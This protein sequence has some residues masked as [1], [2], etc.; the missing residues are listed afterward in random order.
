MY[1]TYFKSNLIFMGSICLLFYIIAIFIMFI[2]RDDDRDEYVK[3]TT[4][5][6]LYK[7]LNKFDYKEH[8]FRNNIYIFTCPDYKLELKISLYPTVYKVKY[9]GYLRTIT[10]IRKILLDPI[11]YFIYFQFI[12][13]DFLYRI[14]IYP[15]KSRISK[16]W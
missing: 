2:K 12:K 11:S 14:L 5:I 16:N 3:I 1:I 15:I 10:S 7:Y 13:Y 6:G 8:N 9:G 4:F